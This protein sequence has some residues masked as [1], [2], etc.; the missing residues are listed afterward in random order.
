[1][2]VFLRRRRLRRRAGWA[3]GRKGDERWSGARGSFEVAGIEDAATTD[4][5][6]YPLI[7]Y[8]HVPKTAGNTI[9]TILGICTPRGNSN[10]EFIINN[11]AAFLDFARNLI[12]LAATR[13]VRAWLTVCRGSIGRSSISSSVRE[14]S[15]STRFP[16]ELQF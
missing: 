6:A 12:G 13:H 16:F 11:R 5:S 4:V 3:K 1:M 9:Q 14:T 7:V 15:G 8:V 10:V 2:T